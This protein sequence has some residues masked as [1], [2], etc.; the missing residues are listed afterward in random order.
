MIV[1]LT[2]VR[3]NLNVILINISFKAKDVEHIFIEKEGPFTFTV[4]LPP[5]KLSKV[6]YRSPSYM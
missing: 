5:T 2:G 6:G 3:W 4:T 1:M